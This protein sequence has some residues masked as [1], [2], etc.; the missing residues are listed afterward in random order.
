VIAFTALA[1]LAWAT[2]RYRVLSTFLWIVFALDLVFVAWFLVEAWG[3]SPGSCENEQA[4]VIIVFL[5]VLDILLAI[6]FVLAGPTQIVRRI[7]ERREGSL[8]ETYA[9]WLRSQE[10][11]H[12]RLEAT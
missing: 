9:D 5:V 12:D 2:R 3:C 10:G 7:R 8:S 1:W 11:D 4:P 6:G